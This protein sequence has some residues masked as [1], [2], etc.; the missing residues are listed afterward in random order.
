MQLLYTISNS[1]STSR[2]AI[3]PFSNI[4]STKCLVEMVMYN[5]GQKKCNFNLGIICA[6]P[7]KEGVN[8]EHSAICSRE[9][10]PAILQHS[11]INSQPPSRLTYLIQG[12]HQI[13]SCISFALIAQWHYSNITLML[14]HQ[15]HQVLFMSFVSSCSKSTF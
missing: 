9:L 12:A 15:P 5:D 11:I 7:L 2:T 13:Q 4:K 6:P 14:P 10:E 8:F 3:L 1:E